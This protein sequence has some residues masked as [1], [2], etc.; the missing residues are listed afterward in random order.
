MSYGLERERE[1]ERERAVIY[2]PPPAVPKM[3]CCFTIG[4]Q[5]HIGPSSVV[6]GS[7]SSSTHPKAGDFPDHL[8]NIHTPTVEAAEQTH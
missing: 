5:A 6:V 2:N 7:L 4:V 8:D 3:W 1:R